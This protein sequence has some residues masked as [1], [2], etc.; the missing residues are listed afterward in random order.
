MR[1]DEIKSRSLRQSSKRNYN[2]KWFTEEK[3]VT[4]FESVQLEEQKRCTQ[5]P[6]KPRSAPRRRRSNS[7]G[8]KGD[9][10]IALIVSMGFKSKEAK[11]ALRKYKGD[12]NQA[13]A[14]LL[15]TK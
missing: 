7:N 3:V 6:Q 13:V 12:V 14:S 1:D 8:S 10:G 2:S 15:H 11:R 5:E 4:A 9:E